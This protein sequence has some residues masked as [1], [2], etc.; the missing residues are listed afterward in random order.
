MQCTVC[1]DFITK[2]RKFNAHKEVLKGQEYLGIKT[3]RFTLRCPSCAAEL[4]F[5]TDPKNSDFQPEHNVKRL[6]DAQHENRIA[7]EKIEKEKA[8]QQKLDP[9][10]GIEQKLTDSKKAF[11]EAEDLVVLRDMST[12]QQDIAS[13]VT[14]SLAAEEAKSSIEDS[15]LKEAFHR[16]RKQRMETASNAEGQEKGPSVVRKKSRLHAVVKTDMKRRTEVREEKPGHPLSAVGDY[17]SS[18][19]ED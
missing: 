4:S 10:Q 13:R 19:E 14:D 2:G 17:L 7:A 12:R 8:E 11:E 9:L 3:Y 6:F 16:L 18:S 5:V 1:N 15:E